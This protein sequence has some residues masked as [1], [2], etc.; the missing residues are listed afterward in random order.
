MF[1][2]LLTGVM[3]YMSL[4]TCPHQASRT[5]LKYNLCNAVVHVARACRKSGMLLF[6]LILLKITSVLFQD[7]KPVGLI[8]DLVS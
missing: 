3:V 2:A 8:Q 4:P 7:M 5:V 1:L 6:T